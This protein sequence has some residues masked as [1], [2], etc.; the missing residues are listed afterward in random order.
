MTDSPLSRAYRA[1]RAIRLLVDDIDRVHAEFVEGDPTKVFDEYPGLIMR[2][3]EYVEGYM[4][5]S[6]EVSDSVNRLLHAL[7]DALF[8][9]DRQMQA[10]KREAAQ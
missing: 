5:G 9:I 6:F 4:N 3:A 2:K 1:K 10:M 8:A 7:D